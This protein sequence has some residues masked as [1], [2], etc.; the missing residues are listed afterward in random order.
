MKTIELV[1]AS[2]PL[3]EYVNELNKEMMLLTLN[4]QP[5]AALISLEDI[6]PE[7]LAL[8]LNP[9]FMGI[10]ENAREEFRAGRK[11]SLETMKQELVP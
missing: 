2:R 1:T 3:S 11:I 4:Q 5:V 9:T 6:D 7:A 10:I 8:S